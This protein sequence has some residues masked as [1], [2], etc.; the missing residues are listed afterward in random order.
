M[1]SLY[2]KH[3]K[4]AINPIIRDENKDN[5]SQSF[6]WTLADFAKHFGDQ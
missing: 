2:S 4:D 6:A 3:I 1:K 5:R